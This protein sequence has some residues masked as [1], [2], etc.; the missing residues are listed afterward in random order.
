MATTPSTSRSN[1]TTSTQNI[2]TRLCIISDTHSHPLFAVDDKSHAFRHP[3]PTA[4]ILLHCGDLTSTGTIDE[5]ERT[6]SVVKSAEAELKL[7]IAGNHDMTLDEPFYQENWRR[8]HAYG[9]KQDVK[10]ARDIW[11]SEEARRAGVVYLEEGVRS[12]ELRTGAKFTIYTNPYTPEFCNWA[13]AYEH[14]DDRFNPSSENTSHSKPGLVPSFSQIDIMM[15]HGPPLNHLSTTRTSEDAGCPHLLRAV[16]RCRP[17]LHCF[18]H[19]H[20]EW[21]AE[22]VQWANAKDGWTDF[23]QVETIE[24]D[25][26][27]V[28]KERRAY[29]DV[30]QG[31]RRPLRFGEETLL[32]NASIMD[33]RYRPINAPW[34]VDLDLPTADAKG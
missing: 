14:D 17:R 2:K 19:I 4:D 31:S 12:F 11:T 10:K 21:G 28:S 23:E 32:I 1:K 25:A 24:T 8:W 33:V 18:G 34:V 26:E 20:E 29:L 9:G 6:F 16:E 22:R 7:V 13:F 30:S 15:T 5:H 3:L 27:Q